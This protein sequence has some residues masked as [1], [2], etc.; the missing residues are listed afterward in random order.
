ML[1]KR[2]NQRDVCLRKDVISPGTA[3]DPE[4]LR[5]VAPWTS[6]L[7]KIC[8]VISIRYDFLQPLVHCSIQRQFNN[9]AAVLYQFS[10]NQPCHPPSERGLKCFPP[11]GRPGSFMYCLTWLLAIFPFFV[12]TAVK[13]CRIMLEKIHIHLA[14]I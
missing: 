13:Y 4:Q 2:K 9:R 6:M 14:L 7:I 10:R 3:S 12:H 8:F 5:F 1:L 11:P